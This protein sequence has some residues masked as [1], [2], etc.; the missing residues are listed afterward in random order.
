MPPLIT[1]RS[2]LVRFYECDAYAHLN[3]TVYARYMQETAFAASIEAGYPHDW[4]AANNRAFLTRSSYIEF[5][6]TKPDLLI[7]RENV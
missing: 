4:Y 1:T 3:N 6:I 2:F 7:A 5:R